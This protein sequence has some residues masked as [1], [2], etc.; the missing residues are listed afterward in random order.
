MNG[1][2]AY[3]PRRPWIRNASL[4]ENVLFG[5]SFDE[6][7]YNKVL[8][9]CGLKKEELSS[10]MVRTEIDRQAFQESFQVEEDDEAQIEVK[11]QL[12]NS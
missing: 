7:W 11:R 8:Q 10:A 1:T 6:S 9:A 2:I 3:S 4:E 12:H 5:R